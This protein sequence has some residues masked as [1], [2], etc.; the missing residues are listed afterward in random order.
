MYSLKK[1]T[2]YYPENLNLSIKIIKMMDNWAT[3]N[4][5]LIFE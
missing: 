5:I 1:D 3:M 4:I 2:Y